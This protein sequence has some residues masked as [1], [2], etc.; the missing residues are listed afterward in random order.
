MQNVSRTAW[1]SFIRC[2][3]CFYLERK[4]KVRPIGMPGYP[5][6]S[7]VDTLL[8]A[9]FDIYR[10]KQEPHPIFRKN[11]LNFVPYKME[12]QK[13]KDFRNNFKG[14]RAKSIKTNFIIYGSI[15]DIWLNKDTEEG[16]I[17]DYKATSTKENINYVT[18]S[19]VYHKSYLRQLD[20]YAYLLKLNNFKVFKTGYWILC[21][22]RDIDQKT[23]GDKLN[24]KID[25]ISYDV[26]TDYIEDTL[27]ELEK[28]YNSNKIPASSPFCDVCR[29]QKETSKL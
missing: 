1:E 25:L 27:V 23:F 10:K 24:F 15:D 28:C 13:L 21:N 22:A 4:L 2:K 7:R 14:V 5:I 29:G 19:K 16:V 18:S 9:E 26:K 6:N 20:F 12:E 3:K 11:K 8:K 17:L